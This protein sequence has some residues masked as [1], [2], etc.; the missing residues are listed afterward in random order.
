MMREFMRH[1][2]PLAPVLLLLAVSGCIFDRNRQAPSNLGDVPPASPTMIE[3]ASDVG[4]SWNP[5]MHRGM[6][7]TETDTPRGSGMVHLVGEI[8]CPDRYRIIVS[9]IENSEKIFIGKTMYERIGDGRWTTRTIPNPHMILNS[10]GKSDPPQDDPARIRLIAEQFGGVQI[11]G[12]VLRNI[13]GHPC[14]EWTRTLTEF[15][16][17][18]VPLAMC[19][20]TRTHALVQSKYGDQVTTFDF[21][22]EVDIKAPL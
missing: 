20:D 6:W 17:P 2:A 18:P 5:G 11:T 16:H 19:Y 3:F 14:R 8:Q 15:N 9:G 12:P 22:S 21:D 7:R 1:L 10:C 4:L 13:N